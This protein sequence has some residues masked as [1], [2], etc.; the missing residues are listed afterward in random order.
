MDTLSKKLSIVY[1]TP[2]IHNI[3]IAKIYCRTHNYMA[4]HKLISMVES[5]KKELKEIIKEL[6]IDTP[7]EISSDV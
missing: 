2:T 7:Y 1:N 3:M 4:V 5:D 6:L